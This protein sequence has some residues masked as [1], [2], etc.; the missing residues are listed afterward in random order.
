MH[1]ADECLCVAIRH[2]FFLLCILVALWS[3]TL[4][5]CPSLTS[6]EWPH[7][8]THVFFFT[9][10]VLTRAYSGRTSLSVTHLEI[11]IIDSAVVF[12]IPCMTLSRNDS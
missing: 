3:A 4:S 10:F 5:Y 11:L 1:G 7:R 9:H 8:P 6:R 2:F 12:L